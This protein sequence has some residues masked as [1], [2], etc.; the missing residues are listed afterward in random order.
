MLKDFLLNFTQEYLIKLRSDMRSRETSPETRPA[1]DKETHDEEL[2]QILGEPFASFRELQGLVDEMD[3]PEEFLEK[4]IP[5]LNANFAGAILVEYGMG[6]VRC[7][8]IGANGIEMFPAVTKALFFS[9][10]SVSWQEFLLFDIRKCERL[11]TCGVEVCILG[12]AVNREL[13]AA[14]SY[15]DRALASQAASVYLRPCGGAG[16]PSTC[17]PPGG[18]QGLAADRSQSCH[19]AGEHCHTRA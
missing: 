15:S 3:L 6:F 19:C 16:Y 18:C 4:S 7:H 5:P 8:C 11:C 10:F 2:A 13:G 12:D 1:K 9:E 14:S 17:G